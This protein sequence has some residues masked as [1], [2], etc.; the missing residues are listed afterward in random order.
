MLFNSY[1]FIICFLPIVVSVFYLLGAFRGQVAAVGWLVAAS[2]FFYGWWNPAYLFLIVG[3]VGLN[4]SVGALLR[5]RRIVS[6]Q[7]TRKVVL[8][9]GVGANLSVIA[10]YKYANFF[11]ENLNQIHDT[12]LTVP[13]LLLPLGISFFTFQQIAYLIDVYRGHVKSSPLLNY[14]LFVTF[15]PQLIAGPIVLHKEMATQFAGRWFAT[16]SSR[17]LAV[18]IAIFTI[19]LVKKVVIA[20]SIA[21]YASPTFDAAAAGVA[22]GFVESWVA[23]LSYTFQIY[24]DFSG[25]SDMAIGLARMFGVRLPINFNSP[26]KATGII[27]FWQRWHMTLT[28]FVNAYVFVPIA[29]PLARRSLAAEYGAWLDMSLRVYVPLMVT[30]FLVGL[31]HGA[32]WTFIV[33]G[34]LHG[35]YLVVNHTWRFLRRSFGQRQGVESRLLQWTSRLV[36]F[37]VVVLAF[38]PFRANNLDTAASVMEGMLGMNGLLLPGAYFEL[39]NGFGLLGDRF[40]ELGA[41]FGEFAFSLRLVAIKLSLLLL[42]VWTLPNTQEIMIRY[43]PALNLSHKDL[44]RRWWQ[45]RLSRGFAISTTALGIFSILHLTRVSEFLYFQF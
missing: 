27:E 22:P 44:G 37:I 40:V 19:G 23:A 16:F 1:I 42:V 43:R 36:T 32:G 9:A 15:F 41:E 3:S 25:Y 26:F 31:W 2:L 21:L 35:C 30:F 17:N 4:Y 24:F 14:A 13:Q 34:L 38:V 20:D 11:I 29:T 18:G 12:G 39:L 28:R 5:N 6:L 7:A 10:Y 33:F 45:W 8:L